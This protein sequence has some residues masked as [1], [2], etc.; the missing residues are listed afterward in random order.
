MSKRDEDR[1]S[2]LTAAASAVEQGLRRF[3][4]L[5][6]TAKQTSLDSEKNLHKASQAL[7][8]IASS[9][10][11]LRTDLVALVQAVSDARERHEANAKHA[12]DVANELKTRTE[13][14]Q[15]LLERYAALGKDAVD[16]NALAQRIIKPAEGAQEEKTQPEREAELVESLRTLEERMG[17]VADDAKRLVESARSDRFDDIARQADSLRQMLAAARNKMSLLHQ[18]LARKVASDKPN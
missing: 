18:G 8:E 10:E 12:Q 16:L 17:N 9:E 14:F 2:R 5:V 6:E 4:K 7:E 3:E 13:T 11:Q 15:S 1:S